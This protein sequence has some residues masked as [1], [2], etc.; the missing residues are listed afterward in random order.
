MNTGTVNTGT[1]T[2]G[3]AEMG[4]PRKSSRSCWTEHSVVHWAVGM[5]PTWLI[6]GHK[7]RTLWENRINRPQGGT[8]PW[9]LLQSHLRDAWRSCSQSN[10]SPVAHHLEKVLRAASRH[11]AFLVALLPRLRA[12]EGALCSS[13]AMVKVSPSRSPAQENLGSEGHGKQ[14]RKFLPPYCLSSILY[15]HDVI[16]NVTD[17]IFV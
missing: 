11:W 15:W 4:C 10:A 17:E 8:I 2:T 12:G 16:T 14:R 1:S 5:T 6:R 3:R 9:N 7:K 13:Q